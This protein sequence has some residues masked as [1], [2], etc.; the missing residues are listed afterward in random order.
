MRLVNST[1]LLR[2]LTPPGHGENEGDDEGEE[3]KQGD[4]ER[5]HGNPPGSGAK[6][7]APSVSN[8]K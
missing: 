7:K 1:T 6:L 8:Q 2:P 5:G 3:N 4:R